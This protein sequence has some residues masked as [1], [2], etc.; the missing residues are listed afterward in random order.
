MKKYKQFLLLS[1]S[2]L[3][4]LTAPLVA[5]ND[6]RSPTQLTAMSSEVV[7]Q[8]EGEIATVHYQ[9]TTVQQAYTIQHAVW[10]EENGQDDI[11]WYKA[12]TPSTKVNL[13]QHKGQGTFRIETYLDA[14]GIKYHL[15][16]KTV[17]LNKSESSANKARPEQAENQAKSVSVKDAPSPIKPSTSSS[18]KR[19]DNPRNPYSKPDNQ[20]KQAPSRQ[21][22]S[23][24]KNDSHPKQSASNSQVNKEKKVEPAHDSKPQ[25]SITNIDQAKGTYTVRVQET[26]YSKR[27]KSVRVPIWSTPNQS[28]LKWYEA[29]PTGNGSFTVQ[30]DI[31]NHQHIYGNYINHIYITYE[32][33]SHVGYVAEN[34]SLPQ[35]AQPAANPILQVTHK[36]QALYQITLQ[37]SFGDGN[38]LFPIWSDING[39]DDLRW[40]TATSLGNGRY[41][42]DFN[43]NHHIGDGLYHVHVY[44]Q[45]GGKVT[46]IMSSTFQVT[47]PKAPAKQTRTIDPTNTYPI[48][49]CTWGA[50]VLAPWA[51]NWW[52]NGGDW[53][54]S[55]K[56]AGF[57]VGT[58]P[59]VGAIACWTDGGYGHVGV[60]THVDS[61]TRIQIQEANYAG[62]RYIA[63]FRGWFD[64]TIAQGTVS[65]IYPY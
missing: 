16:S 50:K 53:A 42:L 2:L 59:Q 21:P 58:T 28:N 38:I 43:A 35:P 48:G 40:Y 8:L 26:S 65:Y 37:N 3:P 31:Q 63:N 36:D 49:E 39:Q 7:V 32:D 14:N 54:A 9:P 62:Q 60:V 15:S 1:A 64:P 19:I 4:S 46:G 41:S 34:I 52:G 45:S 33:G 12:D 29:I 57:H 61:R 55:A 47:P 10:S 13:N 30:F 5:A 20:A 6:V 27:I 56:R 11:V 24:S 51:G 25:I 22:A 18:N 44:R 17:F 23:V